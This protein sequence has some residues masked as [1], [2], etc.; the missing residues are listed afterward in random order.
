MIHITIAPF[1]EKQL[2]RVPRYIT[3]SLL[4][5]ISTVQRSGLNETRKLKGYHDEPLKGKRHGQRSIR[6][7]IAYWAI[8]IESKDGLKILVIEVNKHEY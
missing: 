8:Y 7:N 6:L 1:A 3:T 2:R 5:W 4:S